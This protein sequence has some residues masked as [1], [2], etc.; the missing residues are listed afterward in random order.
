MKLISLGGSGASRSVFQILKSSEKF[1]LIGFLD[2]R[3]NKGETIDGYK[4]LGEFS[5]SLSYK[6]L[7]YKFITGIGSERTFQE[8]KEK[9][10]SCNLEK[11]DFIKILSKKSI[12][13][14]NSES[15]KA[16]SLIFDNVFL[17]YEV[18]IGYLSII[19]TKTYVGH[20]TS[21]ED[22]CI[23]GP[24]CTICGNVKIKSFVYI[25]AGTTIKDHIEICSNVLIGC[26]AVVTKNIT[27]PG[28]YA[29]VPAKRI[30]DF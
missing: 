21:I 9:I 14:T 5:D 3:I 18:K 29:G 6:K 13:E 16:G 19:N 1:K 27:I 28:I 24:N 2:N 4:C 10:S 30:K 22:Y 7:G 20:E 15:I 12:I 25:G 26:G 8:K 23:V 11:N 17:G